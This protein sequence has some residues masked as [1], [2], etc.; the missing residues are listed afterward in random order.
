MTHNAF[1]FETNGTRAR[2]CKIFFKNTLDITGRCIRTVINKRDTGTGV[3][4][5]DKRGRHDNH[6]K[7]SN[8]LIEGVFTPLFYI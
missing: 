4:E 5:G 1:Y 2:V 3:L 7:L 8:D 6:R